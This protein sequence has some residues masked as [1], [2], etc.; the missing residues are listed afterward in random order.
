MAKLSRQFVVIIA[1][2]FTLSFTI[3][4]ITQPILSDRICDIYAAHPEWT[5][6]QES[7]MISELRGFIVQEGVA[8][9]N[10]SAI[11]TWV[12][13]YPPMIL[14]IYRA[15]SLLYDSTQ[16]S[17]S[18]LHAHFT[19]Q[20]LA[21][22]DASHSIMFA[23]GTALV[24]LST[25]PEHST[26]ELFSRILL[27]LCAVMFIAIVLLGMR[28]KIRSLVLLERETLAIAG[29]ETHREITVSGC[30]ELAEL[31][32]SVD[33]MRSALLGAMMGNDGEQSERH[34]W[35]TA[36]SHDLRTPM[37]SM[38]GYMEVLLKQELPASARLYAKRSLAQAD[39]AKEISDMLFSCFTGAP[40]P[41]EEMSMLSVKELSDNLNGRAD[42]LRSSKF[43]VVLNLDAQDDVRLSVHP[44]ALERVLDNI[45][46]NISAHAEPGSEI[47]II[48][49]QEHNEVT[50]TIDNQRSEYD[51]A[52]QKF[53]VTICE[54]LM[55]AMTGEFFDTYSD[56]IYSATL[57]IMTAPSN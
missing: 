50:L 43:I 20:P 54:N 31:A 32:Q 21:E 16:Y 41:V 2:A 57:T 34:T 37:T 11:S 1:V 46:G 48:V 45:F 5:Q 56:G 22:T 15:R 19:Q 7:V 55:H 25:F 44:K 24:A 10:A 47:H 42:E 30:D 39:R 40:V 18:A 36:L 38:R 17:S 35:V 53:G 52:G 51:R 6:S 4:F 26:S 8:A 23:D 29:G 9:T 27:I 12:R 13:R 14:T 49:S 28:R 33:E 3:Y